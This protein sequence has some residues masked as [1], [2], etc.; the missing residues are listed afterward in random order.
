MLRLGKKSAFFV[1]KM[2]S[3]ILL[4]GKKRG[5]MLP[6]SKPVTRQKKRANPTKQTQPPKHNG[7]V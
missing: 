5:G 6:A 7:E 3:F 2:A 1:R 4:D